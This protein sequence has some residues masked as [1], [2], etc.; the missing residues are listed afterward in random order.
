MASV[1]MGELKNVESQS[2]QMQH[3]LTTDADNGK[4]VYAAEKEHSIDWGNAIVVHVVS[5]EILGEEN[6]RSDPYQW[7]KA[8]NALGQR[9]CY[10]TNLE[11]PQL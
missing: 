8:V 3:P 10:T 7:L 9:S 6:H 11:Q 4:A 2:S 1:Y 5:A